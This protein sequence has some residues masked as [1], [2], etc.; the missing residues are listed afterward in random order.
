MQ[1]D[2]DAYRRWQT[3]ERVARRTKLPE[4]A[5]AAEAF[6]VE[7]TGSTPASPSPVTQNAQALV[8]IE[9][10]RY[11]EWQVAKRVAHHTGTAEDKLAARRAHRAFQM[12][13][14]VRHDQ[15]GAPL[16]WHTE[17]QRVKYEESM[18]R[19][20]AKRDAERV[21]PAKVDHEMFAYIMGRPY[22]PVR[23]AAPGKGSPRSI[24]RVLHELRERGELAF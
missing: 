24:D 4:D 22:D 10:E 7:M 3:A 5:A 21:T 8:E 14:K 1:V 17:E 13:R 12:I 15:G 2:R 19:L 18:A 20:A 23:D 16:R 6:Y 9:R 11:A